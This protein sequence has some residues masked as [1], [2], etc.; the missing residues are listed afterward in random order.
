MSEGLYS[1][2]D[3][4]FLI[5]CKEIGD[6]PLISKAHE[7]E[8]ALSI[9]SQ[10]EEL[11]QN[12]LKELVLANLRLVIKIS[13]K[14]QNLGLESS[15]L[16]SEG[17]IGL[18]KAAQKFDPD[19]GVS[20]STYASYWIKQSIKRALSNKSRAIRL[21]TYLTQ[22]N[23]SILNYCKQHEISKGR[24]ATDEEIS[25][26]LEVPLKK[27]QKCKNANSVN[28]FTFLNEKFDDDDSE[29]MESI[30]DFNIQ[31]PSETL[32]KS[33]DISVL[34]NQLDDSLNERERYVI[35]YRFG[36]ENKEKRT[37]EQ[38]GDEF[39]ITRERIRQ[40]EQGALRKLESSLRKK[41]N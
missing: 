10:D 7:I 28:Y 40:I 17:N 18:V 24:E 16:V 2:K 13:N 23:H 32:S 35:Q 8:L 12:A 15:D 6:Y 38:L 30:E 39:G 11:A 34:K 27:I 14:Y 37:L 33:D 25:S 31:P 9:R 4:N 29:R 21:P 26:A 3:K 1:A 20:F 36:L 5:Y 41:M 19:R 22:L